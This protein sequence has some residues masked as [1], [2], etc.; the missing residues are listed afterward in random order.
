MR[1][2]LATL[3]VAAMLALSA[4]GASFDNAAGADSGHAEHSASAAA[5]TQTATASASA[6]ESE[7]T[8]S[9]Q[10]SA[11]GQAQPQP[12]DNMPNATAES[13]TVMP[14][15]T[16]TPKSTAKPTATTQAQHEGD[17]DND[18][19]GSGD[20]GNGHGGGMDDNG[21]HAAASHQPSPSTIP[22][23]TASPRPTS[24]TKTTPSPTSKPSSSASAQDDKHGGKGG[25]EDDKQDAKTY[26][27][28]IADFSFTVD[29]LEIHPGDSV[30]F[31]NRDKIKH[32]ATADDG[33]FDTGLLGQDESKTVVFKKAGEFGY[34]CTPH[35]GMRATIV[36]KAD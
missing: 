20:D 25:S 11:T 22:A 9:A 27:V 28:E 12:D 8:A 35:P 16:A 18:G 7:P 34:Y 31:V 21:S 33:S 29:K 19:H 17:D 2:F 4:C 13:A 30:T 36:V 1:S 3:L 23:K 10:A 6:D 15:S 24:G 26:V 5:Q 14:K 32:T